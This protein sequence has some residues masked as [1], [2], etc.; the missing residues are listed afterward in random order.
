MVVLPATMLSALTDALPFGGGFE[1]KKK[2]KKKKDD[3]SH[4]TPEEARRAAEIAENPLDPFPLEKEFVRHA[5]PIHHPSCTHAGS[6][7]RVVAVPSAS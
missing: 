5:Q 2:K 1:T 6:H 3:T 7:T 4:L